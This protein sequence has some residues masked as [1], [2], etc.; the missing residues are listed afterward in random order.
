MARSRGQIR[1]RGPNRYLVRIYLGRIDGKRK[2]KSKTVHGTRK[3]AERKLTEMLRM[4]DR[5]LVSSRSNEKL[6]AFLDEWLEMKKTKVKPATWRNY[7]TAIRL[8]LKP[9]L[10]H[11][12]LDQLNSRL[13]QAFIDDLAT[14][15]ELSTSYIRQIHVTLRAA[16]Q[17]AVNWEMLPINPADGGRLEFPRDE[18]RDYRILSR[19]EAVRLLEATRGDRLHALWDL[20]LATG[21]RPQEAFALK[22]EDLEDG[23]LRVR[24]VIAI[25]RE[26]GTKWEVDEEMKTRSSRRRIKLPER[27]LSALRSH[28]ARQARE[29]LEAG[30]RYQRHGFVFTRSPRSGDFLYHEIARNAFKDALK[31]AGLPAEDI[32]LYDLRHTHISQLIMAGAGLKQV[33]ARAGHSSIT[34]T[35]DVYS[36]IE[37]RAEEEMAQMT[38]KLFSRGAANG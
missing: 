12:R 30:P 6:D 28:Q 16:L 29:M 25:S 5:G 14:E 10:G 21:L 7:E 4:K 24:R 2:Y 33:P 27:T 13:I 9:T 15:K 38:E 18:S 37:P 26:D 36:H 3:D 8:Y 32:R 35:A 23:W 19:P 31:A 20:L 17:Q 34:V 22:W 11:L 1:K